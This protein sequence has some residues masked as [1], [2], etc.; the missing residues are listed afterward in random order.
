MNKLAVTIQFMLYVFISFGQIPMTELLF[1]HEIESRIVENKIR[2]S[3]AA[4]NYTYIGN[5]RSA[6]Q[7]SD[8]PISW[9]VDTLNLENYLMKNAISEIIQIAKDKE[10]IIISES[11]L[12]PQHRIFAKQ[13]IE[14]LSKHGFNHLGLETF[15]VNYDH[16]NQLLDQELNK[17]GYPLASPFSGTFTMEPQ[18]SNLVRSAFSHGYHFFGYE[19]AKKVPGKDREE[20]QADN[21]VQYINNTNAKKIILLCGWHHAIESDRLKRKQFFYMAKYI[22]DKTGID[23]L[24]IYQDNFTEKSVYNEH[25]ILQK[26]TIESPQ[27]FMEGDQVAHISKEVDIEVIHPKTTYIDNRASWLFQTPNHKSYHIDTD[28]ITMKY[29]IFVKAFLKTDQ[30]DAVPID[31]VELRHQYERKPLVLPLG[32]YNILITNKE[33]EMQME[34]EVKED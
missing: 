13:I 26:L 21:V 24:T 27:V 6:I 10:I 18:M 19:R 4:Y 15:T 28:T 7:N 8:I 31:I 22:K 1:S 23:P 17:R 29:P 33:E 11:H 3:S 14:G 34:I 25:P 2:S 16:E 32:S 20:I 12:K 9:G 5:Y 30:I